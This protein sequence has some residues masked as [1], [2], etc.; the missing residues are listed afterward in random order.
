MT[1]EEVPVQEEPHACRPSGQE[2]V[3]AML[4][5]SR[6]VLQPFPDTEFLECV[7]LRPCDL[8]RLQQAN[9]QVGRN[10]FLQHGFYQYHHLLLAKDQEGHYILGVPGV[11]NAQERYM[12]GMF[13]FDRFKPANGYDRGWQFGY[14][15][16][17][18]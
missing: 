2:Q 9:C 1:S 6:P 8:V 11:V 14:W 10:T 16:R 7:Q 3:L 15:C 18:I 5:A 12:A 17:E 4:F 13:A